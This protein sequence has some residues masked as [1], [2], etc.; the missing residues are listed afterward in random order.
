[1]DE[2]GIILPPGVQAHGS[3]P[4]RH[5][6]GVLI[7]NRT[8]LPDAM[9][10]NAVETHFVENAS[11]AWGHPE[12]FQT[13]AAEGGMLA[14]KRFTTPG[15]VRDEIALSRDLAERD[16][17][18]ASTI[19]FMLNAAFGEGMENFHEEERTVS[20]FNEIAKNM[21][22]DRALMEVYREFLIAN[23]A[24]TVSLFTRET[25][26]FRPEA[27]NRL[28]KETLAAPLMGVLRS[29]NIRVLDNDMFG[30]GTLAFDP[31]DDSNLRNWLDEFF[32]PRT[33]AARKAEMARQDRVAASMFTGRIEVGYNEQDPMLS[34][35]VV[36]LLNPRMVHRLTGPK[37]AAKY[38]RPFL[39]RNFPL[40]EAKRLLNLMDYALLQGG[41]NFIVVAKKGSDQ[42]PAMPEEVENLK[43]VVRTASRTGVIVGDHRLSFE[44]ITPNLESLLSPDKRH[45]IGRKLSAAL[46]RVPEPPTDA[47]EEAMKASIEI[48]SRNITGDR[49]LIKR[50]VERTTYDEAFKRNRIFRNG[51]AK[52]WFPKIILQ[53]ADFFLDTV[54]KLRDRGDIPR[55]W[56][57]EAGGFDYE[58]AL[59]QRQREV[60]RGDDDTLMPA[61]VPFS[62]PAVG[63]QDNPSD[64][65][66]RGGSPDNGRPGAAPSRPTGR[67]RRINRNAGE[68]ITAMWDDELDTTVRVGEI[69][70]AILEQYPDY[71]RGRLT[72]FEAAALDAGGNAA[73]GP[74]SIIGVNA[75]YDVPEVRAVRLAPG[76]SL[77]CGQ[78]TG[79]EALVAKALV[80]RAPE[81][82]VHDAEETA[83]RWGF[84]VTAVVD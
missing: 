79:D 65:R 12:S 21:N 34:M 60:D 17:D 38:P 48:A 47:A 46:M 11:M 59:S 3:P 40:I 54:L 56:A 1:V 66:P 84:P 5:G 49:R 7:D 55:K 69:T 57:V 22:L 20:L 78:R 6:G 16:D 35:T 26:E 44:I 51:P 52:L 45:M 37:G 72:S 41:M 64:G 30:T 62:D 76:L 39:T 68:T 31:C 14:R 53:G 8:D 29:E 81:Y 9:V 32:S 50:H 80:F 28:F 82:T 70:Y 10:A 75:D 36:Y 61:A 63:P 25:F 43:G 42:R 83:A 73:E 23:Q 15:S 74:L 19:D 4:A 24:T 13:Y 33:S 67:Q 27:T 71:T 58:A 18:V 2:T 77:L